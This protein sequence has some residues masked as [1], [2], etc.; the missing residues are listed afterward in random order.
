MLQQ[1]AKQP[2]WGDVVVAEAEAMRFGIKVA[3]EYSFCPLI[4]ESNAQKIVK[5]IKGNLENKGDVCRVISKIQSYII[6][7]EKFE[8]RFVPRICNLATH[9]SA[10][11]AFSYQQSVIWLE[12][13]P[14]KVSC[15]L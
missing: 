2:F 10:K 4:V 5:L 12:E 7:K 8:V 3:I 9:K 13:V 1:G 14:S 11:L 6:E 15:I